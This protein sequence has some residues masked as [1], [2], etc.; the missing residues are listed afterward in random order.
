MAFNCIPY[1]SMNTARKDIKGFSTIVVI[2]HGIKD[3]SHMTWGTPML[4]TK[5]QYLSPGTR[6]SNRKGGTNKLALG[7]N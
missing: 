2:K 3:G 7:C 6:D 5:V 4:L 1:S